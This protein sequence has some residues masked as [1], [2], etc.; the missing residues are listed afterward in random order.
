[1]RYTLFENQRDVV[2]LVARILLMVLFVMFGWSKLT[3]FA[4]TVAYMASTGAP[5]PALS[6]V[7]AVVMELVVGVAL[8]VGFFTRPLALLLALYTLGTAIIG[9]HYWNMTGAMQYDNMIH[10]YKNIAIIGGLLLLCVSGPGKYSL[11][12]R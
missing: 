9:H 10:F 3:G 5:A 6:A 4:G 7:I 12:R 2:L 11:D 8:L 1:M